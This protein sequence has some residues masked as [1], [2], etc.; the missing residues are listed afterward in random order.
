MTNEIHVSQKSITGS[1]TFVLENILEELVKAMG[2]KN[3]PNFKDTP[4]RVAK[5]L[6]VYQ[7]LSKQEVEESIQRHLKAKFPTDNKGLIIQDPIKAFSMCPHHMLMIEYD[8]FVGYVPDGEAI[9]LSKL[10]RIA[11][12]MA[13]YPYIQEDYTTELADALLKGIQC[14]GTMVVVKG[15]HNCMRCR[16]VKQPGA[17]TTTSAITGVFAHPPEGMN[18]RQ[19]FLDL[20]RIGTTL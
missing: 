7:G 6:E 4:K 19:E 15:V 10:S 18:P 5:W 3:D 17:I 14:K 1:R 13:R 16:G 20:L 8:V 2:W 9:G 11:I 12:D